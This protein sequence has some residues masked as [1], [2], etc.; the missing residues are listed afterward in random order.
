[1][2]VRRLAPTIAVVAI[3]LLGFMAPVSAATN[4]CKYDEARGRVVCEVSGDGTV[5]PPPGTP[6]LPDDPGLRYVYPSTDPVIGDCY[7]WSNLPGGLDAWDPANDPAVIAIT[8]RLPLCPSPPPIDP[9]IRAWEVFRSWDLAPPLPSV[10]P[11]ATGITGVPTHV[12]ADAPDPIVHTETLPDGRILRVR[13]TV[14]LLTVD[15]GDG[16]ATFHDPSSATGYPGGSAHHA[17]R[18]KTCPAFYR[19]NHPSGPLCH[20]TLDHYTMTIGHRW[21]GAYSLGATWVEL[22]SLDQTIP[23]PYDVDEARGLNK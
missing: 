9:E 22:G 20:P 5:T 13:A 23:V 18:L 17:Y 21:V 15:W 16:H 3:A 4:R 19:H 12:A 8:T 2:V 7:Y 6:N 14:T 11:P 1:M 10:S